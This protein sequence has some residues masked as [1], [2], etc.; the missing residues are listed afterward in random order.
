M[1]KRSKRALM[2]GLLFEGVLAVSALPGSYEGRPLFLDHHRRAVGNFVWGY[3]SALSNDVPDDVL[4]RSFTHPRT[5][6]SLD[7]L[8]CRDDALTYS[9]IA[10]LMTVDSDESGEFLRFYVASSV[11]AEFAQRMLQAES[12]VAFVSDNKEFYQHI[13]TIPDDEFHFLVERNDAGALLYRYMN[14]SDCTAIQDLSTV[15]YVHWRIQGKFAGYF[16]LHD[17]GGPSVVDKESA[18]FVIE[19]TTPY[20]LYRTSQGKARQLM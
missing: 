14:A 1:H 19:R 10:G 6:S 11:N 3:R 7:D 17:S 12:V 2:V 20:S 9:E 16:H 18:G 4:R 5:K 15:H 13:T 8:F